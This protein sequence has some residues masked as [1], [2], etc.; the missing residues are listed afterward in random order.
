MIRLFTKSVAVI[1]VQWV[2]SNL[3]EIEEFIGKENVQYP[4]RELLQVCLEIG[5]YW[6]H[7]Q[8]NDWIIKCDDNFEVIPA[9]EFDKW[10]ERAR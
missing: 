7:L 4:N 2:Q 8:Y 10:F 9:D 1:G 5:G 3:S 6:Q